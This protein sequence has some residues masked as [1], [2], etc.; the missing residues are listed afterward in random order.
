MHE[1]WVRLN[2]SAA[3]SKA[4]K[5]DKW[6]RGTE[7]LVSANIRSV[8]GNSAGI[9]VGKVSPGIFLVKEIQ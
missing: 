5:K 1:Y 2:R 3:L 9:F 8:E 6:T 4:P 7:R